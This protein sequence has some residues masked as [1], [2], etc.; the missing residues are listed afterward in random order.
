M[1]SPKAVFLSLLTFGVFRCTA[2]PSVT[3]SVQAVT[4]AF[5]PSISTKQR[6]QEA[7]GVEASLMAHRLGIQSPL[8]RATQRRLVPCLV[9]TSIPS[10][11]KVSSLGLLSFRLYKTV[12]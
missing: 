3:G 2:I 11:V 9:L 6:R 12:F 7:K 1:R 4:G 10:M 5:L 8:S